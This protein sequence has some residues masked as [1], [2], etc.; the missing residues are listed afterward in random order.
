MKKYALLLLIALGFSS[1]LL[2]QA[3]ASASQ[4]TALSLSNA[5]AITFTASGT[6]AGTTISLPF[7]TV[8]DY[9]NGVASAV[10]Q[11]K[12]QS[13][14]LFNV[15]I[16]TS[17]A[18]FTYAGA[19]T[20]APVMPV[21]G[22]LAAQITA[23]ATGGTVATSFNNTYASLSSSAQALISGCL[24]GGNQTFSIQY[25]TT[26]GFAYPAG[27]YTASVVYTATQP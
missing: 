24:N 7:A 6:N 20:P 14:K 21:S 5:I 8:S 27:T 11:L 25:K 17:T 15:T 12:V 16:N 2:A 23:N 19:T 18:N 22:V 10:Q 1:Q 9:T 4:S 26:P 13:N 3:T